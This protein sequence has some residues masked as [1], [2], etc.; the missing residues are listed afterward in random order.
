MTRF[1]PLGLTGDWFWNK[2]DVVCIAIGRCLESAVPV[3]IFWSIINVTLALFEV[4]LSHSLEESIFELKK[5][6]L[7]KQSVDCD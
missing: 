7:T 5:T 2:K 3:T 1:S 4:C 6:K